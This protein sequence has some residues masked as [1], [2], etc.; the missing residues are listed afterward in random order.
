[1]ECHFDDVV[2]VITCIGVPLGILES[3]DLYIARDLVVDVLS[4]FAR[5]SEEF[6]WGLVLCRAR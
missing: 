1:M 5:K 4:E 3:F 2:V 6:G